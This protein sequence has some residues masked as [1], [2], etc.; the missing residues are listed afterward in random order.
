MKSELIEQLRETQSATETLAE[1][2]GVEALELGRVM[3][4]GLCRLR[5]EERELLSPQPGITHS[6]RRF[7]VLYTPMPHHQPVAWVQATVL[8]HL[9]PPTVRRDVEDGVTPLGQVLAELP[10]F[11]R[12]S[13]RVSDH[14]GQDWSGERIG[15]QSVALLSFGELP[16]PVAVVTENVYQ[17][18]IDR[19][20]KR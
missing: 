18:A 6:Y 14:Y 17:Q 9:L 10:G 11:V 13:V 2:V 3:P 7:A 20:M 19:G 5:T 12:E 15:I 4:R 8:T 16:L 1:W